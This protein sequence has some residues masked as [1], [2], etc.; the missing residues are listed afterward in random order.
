M[1]LRRSLP[2]NP[3]RVDV[4]VE[5]PMEFLHL[6]LPLFRMDFKVAGI[7]VLRSN[8]V[9]VLLFGQIQ[10]ELLGHVFRPGVN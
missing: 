5:S 9:S 2:V 10:P 3:G 8:G 6:F 1:E 4:F 7:F